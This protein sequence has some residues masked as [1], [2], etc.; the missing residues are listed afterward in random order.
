MTISRDGNDAVTLPPDLRARVL[1]A[2]RQ[3]RATGRSTPAVPD[4]SPVEAFAREVDAFSAVLVALDDAGW[5]TRVL[6]DLDVQALVGHLTGVESDVQRAL[7][8]DPSVADAEHVASTQE[9]ALRQRG[10]SAVQT[11]SEWRAGADATLAVVTAGFDLDIEVAMHGMRLTAG[12]LLVVRAFELWTHEND[13]R[14]AVG[15]PA[16]SPDASTLQLMTALAVKLLPHASPRDER[17][18]APVAVHL[19]LTG[20]GGGTWDVA[21]GDGASEDGAAGAARVSIVADAVEFCRLVAN[22]VAP[23]ELD[24]HVTGASDRAGDVLHVASSLAL[25]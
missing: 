11:R 15:L 17:L 1:A 14:R 24:L 9:A 12:D 7:A 5:A 4:I 6:R 20:S 13:I 23:D 21:L 22:R 10:L 19:V 3:A 25:D 16:S 18:V 2:S 8:G